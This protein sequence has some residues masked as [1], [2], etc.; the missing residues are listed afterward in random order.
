M[1]GGDPASHGDAGSFGGY[2]ER[3]AEGSILSVMTRGQWGYALFDAGCWGYASVTVATLAP[4]VFVRR[5]REA[6]PVQKFAHDVWDAGER[7]EAA[8][9]HVRS[10]SL[11]RQ[12]K[13]E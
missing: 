11:P 10:P 7:E 3:T 12:R 5:I 6:M 9:W 1:S 8:I 2:I 13:L 4:L